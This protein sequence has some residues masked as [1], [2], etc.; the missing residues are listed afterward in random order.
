MS[1]FRGLVT[2]DDGKP[3]LPGSLHVNRRLSQWLSF[4]ADGRVVIHPGKVELGQGILTVLSQIAADELDV[5][6]ARVQVSPAATPDSPDEGV[7]SGS[8]STQDCGSA[9]RHACADARRIFLGVTA[10][11]SGVPVERLRVEDGAFLGPEGEVGSYWQLADQQLLEVE[12]SPEAKPKAV[13][14]RRLVGWTCLTRSS[15]RRATYMICICRACCT[16]AWCARPRAAPY[17]WKPRR[18]PKASNWCATAI[19][20]R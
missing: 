16:P 4:H 14:E 6:L 5:A 8:L 12:A 7:T 10:Q 17:C 9:I 20:W 19:S 13:G 3:R 11:R 2:P 1:G 18:R 15:A